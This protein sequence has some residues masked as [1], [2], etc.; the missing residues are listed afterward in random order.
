M[1]TLVTGG[2][3]YIGSHTCV[4]L[5]E[6]G[7][8]VVVVDSLVNGSSEALRRVAELT[9]TEVPLYPIDLRNR[10]ALRDVFRTY[11]VD[12]VLHFAALKAV[13]ESVEQPLHY[14]DNNLGATLA[15]LEVMGEFDVETIVFS[16]SA[17]VYGAPA[18]VPIAEDAALQPTN[19]Y[20]QT[21]LFS[22]QFIRDRQ[23]A[24]PRQR[25]AL[26]RYFNPAG[27][28]PSGRIGESPQATPN[29]LMPYVSGVAQ[30][31][32]PHLRIFGDDYP[33]ADGTGVRD[34]IHVVD[35]ARGHLAALDT[36]ADPDGEFGRGGILTVNLG[37]GRGYSVRE[38]VAAFERA[39]GRAIPCEVVGRRAGDIATCYA[40]P[41]LAE[42]VMGWRAERGLEAICADAWRWQKDNPGG[43]PPRE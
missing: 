18:S 16:S 4:E 24:Q 30:G 17:T 37:T 15:L 2:A 8:E 22:E 12:A 6:A 32:L 9:G 13:G 31:H 28:H 5:I 21:K 35:L 20:G 36:L 3:G 14:Y 1:R 11:S 42:N 26:L 43:F 23:V 27:A 29:N 34:Y 38:V 39:S 7:H 40:D 10:D 19:P 25:A 41:T 33:T